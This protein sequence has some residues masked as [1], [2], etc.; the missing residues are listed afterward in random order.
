MIENFRKSYKI[1]RSWDENVFYMK[2]TQN[3]ETNPN[4][5]PIRPPHAPSIVNLQLF[6]SSSSAWKRETPRILSWMFPLSP[7]SPIPT[8]GH[9]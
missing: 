5:Q 6:P 8:L 2:V 1:N 3:D 9:P 7:V 4:T